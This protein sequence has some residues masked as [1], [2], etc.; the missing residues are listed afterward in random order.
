MAFNPRLL[1]D[2]ADKLCEDSNYDDESK[3]R[4]SIS[5]AYYAAHLTARCKL[6]SSG[7]DFPADSNVHREVINNLKKMDKRVSGMLYNLRKKRNNADYELGMEI[8]K[9]HALS[10]LKSSRIIVDKIST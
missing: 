5:R 3:Y 7:I 4:T 1:L 6:E 10:C 8:K 9:G 2:L